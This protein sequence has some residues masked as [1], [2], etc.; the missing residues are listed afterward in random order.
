MY[1]LFIV[2]LLLIITRRMLFVLPMFIPWSLSWVI[3]KVAYAVCFCTLRIVCGK[4]FLR[5]QESHT[6]HPLNTRLQ[7]HSVNLNAYITVFI[8]ETWMVIFQ[9]YSENTRRKSSGRVWSVCT[10]NFGDK[11]VKLR[12]EID[13]WCGP[14][15]ASGCTGAH[16]NSSLLLRFHTLFAVYQLISPDILCCL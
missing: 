4:H 13:F 8:S 10:D 9:N 6:I 11:H 2:M 1:H 12:S 5:L 7:Q 15:P 14:L 3:Q 16:L